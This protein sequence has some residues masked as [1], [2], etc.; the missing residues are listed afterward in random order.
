MNI[1]DIVNSK[2]TRVKVLILSPNGDI[3]VTTPQDKATTGIVKNI[4]LKKMES[5]NERIHFPQECFAI[6]N[7][8][9]KEVC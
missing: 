8:C 2:T 3:K 6:T 5:C 9:F 7:G 4:A 1:E